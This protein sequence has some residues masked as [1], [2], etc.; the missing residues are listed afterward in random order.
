MVNMDEKTSCLTP[1]EA[2]DIAAE[3]LSIVRY[4]FLVQIEDGIASAS[5][6]SSLE[7]AD[8]VLMGW[9]DSDSNDVTIPDETSFNNVLKNVR[10]MEKNIIK[11][12]ELERDHDIDGM[13][14]ML[15]KISESV[16]KIRGAYQPDFPLPT[17]AEIQR[18]VKDEWD[19]EMGNINPDSAN[20]ASGLVNETQVEDKESE[21]NES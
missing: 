16:A 7:Y 14:S 9:P 10:N 13:T 5:Q 19:E 1:L 2:L 17:F 3:R 15:A 6:R 11:F 18:V 4:V 12:S 20:V 8:A 21:A